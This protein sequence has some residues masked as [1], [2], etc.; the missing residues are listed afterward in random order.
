[1]K[2][3]FVLLVLMISL[4]TACSSEIT[5]DSTNPFV[6]GISAN[7]I[8]EGDSVLVELRLLNEAKEP[9]SV[10]KEGEN[11]I[12]ELKLSNYSKSPLTYYRWFK[13][14]RDINLDENLFKVYSKED[15]KSIGL[16][17][18]GWF[19]DKSMQME[20][21]FPSQSITYI[22]CPWYNI[23]DFKYGDLLWVELHKDASKDNPYLSKG[24]YYSKFNVK[25]NP[26]SKE[27]GQKMKEKELYI[28][29]D[30]R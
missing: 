3:Y 13:E 12:F 21:F 5:E 2:D 7:S 23:K 1:M 15:G 26:R 4:F 10:F 16:A 19:G 24:H 18:V 27:E 22:R 30:I 29:F 14:E 17:W 11:I 28:E 9:T 6:T 25:Y 8:V 20:Y